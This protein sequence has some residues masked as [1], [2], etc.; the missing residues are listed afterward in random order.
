MLFI[1]LF[2]CTANASL[3]SLTFDSGFVTN[4]INND[5]TVVAL[6]ATDTI[7][8]ITVNRSIGWLPSSNPQST[9]TVTNFNQTID[10]NILNAPV[11]LQT[12][13]QVNNILTVS[14]GTVV[15]WSLGFVNELTI[16]GSVG[17]LVTNQITFN[18]TPNV[19]NCPLPTP[20]GTSCDD[21][22]TVNNVDDYIDLGNNLSLHIFLQAGN[23]FH[24]LTSTTPGLVDCYTAEGDP[25]FSDI[26]VY[27]EVISTIP[28]PG[29]LLLF[30]VG[31]LGMAMLRTKNA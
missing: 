24:C 30:S 15:G 16:D 18:E 21:I 3:I 6:D 19:A 12:F 2:T 17:G 11:V 28:E 8:G 7:A 5:S 26:S 31:L 20:N 25:G 10:T 13:N 22:Y 1:L 27:A 9:L 29:V 23:N 4:D 14:S